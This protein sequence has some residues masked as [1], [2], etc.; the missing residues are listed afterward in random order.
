MELTFDNHRSVDRHDICEVLRNWS[1]D[2]DFEAGSCAHY[3]PIEW[4]SVGA[5]QDVVEE[6]ARVCEKA[7]PWVGD[8]PGDASRCSACAIIYLL[9]DIF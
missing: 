7:R 4:A 3:L 1:E 6:I 9:F 2:T 8:A 5:H